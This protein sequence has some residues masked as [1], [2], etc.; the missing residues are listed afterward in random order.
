M[1]NIKILKE[2]QLVGGTDNTPVYP[3][4]STQAIYCQDSEGNVPQGVKPKLEDRLRDIENSMEAQG[5]VILNEKTIHVGTASITVPSTASE[6]NALPNTTKYGYSFDLDLNTSTYVLTITLKDQDGT[7]LVSKNVNFPMESTVVNGSYNSQLKKIVLTLKNN[8]TIDIPVADLISGLQSEITPVSP[9]DADLVDD[10][11]STHKFVTEQEKQA[12]TNKSGF[13]GNYNDLSGKPTNVSSF[14]NDAGYLTSTDIEQEL[15]AKANTSDVYDKTTIDTALTS[16]QN[17][18]LIIEVN[19]DN[20]SIPNGTYASIT[21]ALAAGKEV[22]V[23]LNNP[24]YTINCHLKGVANSVYTF[25]SSFMVAIVNVII[26]PN[27]TISVNSDSVALESHLDGKVDK[28]EDAVSGNLA[29][30]TSDGN[31]AD[32]GLALSTKTAYSNKGSATKVPKIST[33][34]LGQ[35]TSISEVTI[36][37]PTVPDISTSISSDGASDTKTAS[38]KAVKTYVDTATAG[39]VT[40]STTGLKIEVVASLP[41]NPDSNTI[42]IVQ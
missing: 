2:D 24:L 31:I 38:P 18:P 14:T 4:S 16:K 8:N 21:A 40:S 37:Q 29:V 9:L 36:T 39:I 6:V 17:T 28:V 32:S 13:S 30:L 20:P 3:V 25:T 26:N 41:A 34:T 22:I 19:Y 1:A 27:D 5:Y 33:N 11:N 35:V 15:G 42:Y 10:T 7:S 12:W 23:K